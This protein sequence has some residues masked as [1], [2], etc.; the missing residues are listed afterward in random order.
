M[1]PQ[2]LSN[3][4]SK[5]LILPR[6]CEPF[7]L[8]MLKLKTMEK[9]SRTPKA[10]ANLCCL[11]MQVSRATGST[12]ERHRMAVYEALRSAPWPGG[13]ARLDLSFSL[14]LPAFGGL[15]AS[16]W[17]SFDSICPLHHVLRYSCCFLAAVSAHW[18]QRRRQQANFLRIIF[19]KM[20]LKKFPWLPW[21]M[22][23][24]GV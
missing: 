2:A 7:E 14:F 4:I 10:R 1:A 19:K 21:L 22:F 11:C 18:S 3:L 24:P 12:R 5:T 15:K 17:C 9:N 13:F 6:L 20:S 8:K 23:F 16:S